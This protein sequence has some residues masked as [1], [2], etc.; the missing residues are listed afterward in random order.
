MKSIS[1][2][3]RINEKELYK[4]F[5]NHIMGLP[6]PKGVTQDEIDNRFVGS[7]ALIKAVLRLPGDKKRVDLVKNICIFSDEIFNLLF[8]DNQKNYL[9]LISR[10]LVNNIG[11]YYKE[12]NKRYIIINN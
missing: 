5:F 7:K 3:Q 2:G 9:E 11:K 10:N 8:V 1:E 4:F 6:F 12:Y